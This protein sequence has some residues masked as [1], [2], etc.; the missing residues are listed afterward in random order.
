MPLHTAGTHDC[1]LDCTFFPITTNDGQQRREKK[2]LI[3]SK[4][5]KITQE[6]HHVLVYNDGLLF[7][8]VLGFYICFCTEPIR[9]RE[10]ALHGSKGIWRLK[11][12]DSMLC[13]SLSSL[14]LFAP[15]IISHICWYIVCTECNRRG[16]RSLY[17]GKAPRLY[18]A[19]EPVL[20]L[21]ASDVSLLPALALGCC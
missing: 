2:I 3:R 10:R 12:C 5:E 9:K 21:P 11:K 14:S 4:R 13:T 7:D 20:L 16:F 18:P 19:C 17:N 6:W 8:I 1:R 15:S